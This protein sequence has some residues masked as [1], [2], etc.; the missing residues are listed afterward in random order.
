MK[1][2]TVSLVLLCSF[3]IVLAGCGTSDKTS[4]EKE[5][6]DGQEKKTLRVVTNADYSPMEFQDKGELVGF[7]ME[8]ITAMGKEAGYDVKLEHVG[9]DP[10]FVELDKKRAQVGASAITINKKREQ[11]YDF[12]A[13][14]FYASQKIL[15]PQGSSIKS[16][17]DLKGKKVAVQMGT[18]AN[19]IMDKLYGADNKNIKK[20]ENNILAIMELTKGGADAV[21]ADNAV[22]E[23]YA[24][25]NP[26]QKLVVIEDKG[27]F[28]PEFYG[29]MLQK[30][31][32][33]LKKDL[34]K[35]LNTLLDN[36]E[37][38]KIYQKWLG[39]EPDVAFLKAQQKK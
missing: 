4:G 9:W 37:Y 30:G 33:Q 38:T 18:T 36:G 14:Y 2:F 32:K 3:L 22:V 35:A 27:A 24:K 16:A 11:S 34:D 15:V 31:D 19:I 29:F 17:A 20:F 1:K 5:N 10:I 39:I 6:K 8:L 23:E 12:T 21:V 7:D 28:D 26:K 13:P 25:N